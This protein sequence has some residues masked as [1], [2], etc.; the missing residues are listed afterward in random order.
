MEK[1]KD[2]YCFGYSRKSP[3]DRESTEVS[4]NNQN[5]LIKLTCL[6]KEWILISI[7]EDWDIS[8][9]DEERKG[10]LKQIEASKNFK[11][12]NPDKEVYLIGKDSKRLLRNSSFF[13]K[14]FNELEEVGVKIYSIAKGSFLK[15]SDMG[16]R[17]M[18]VVDEQIIYDAKE[19][20]KLNEQLKISKGLP[21]IPSPFGYKYNFKYNLERKKVPID[22]TKEITEWI[23][24]K[25]EAEI[26]RNVINSYLNSIDYRAIIKENHLVK[27]KYY[28]II[29]NTKMGIYSGYIVYKKKNGKEVRYKGIHE[30]IIPVELWEKLN[31]TK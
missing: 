3:D 22:K 2:V 10:F 8:G 30:P 5:D 12:E 15:Y 1:D 27:T 24:N 11:K 23:I 20:S 25:K 18:S 28:R 7:E 14:I 31:D 19:Y 4:I 13:K 26:I 6:N 21:C 29:K 16:D 17:I 9:S